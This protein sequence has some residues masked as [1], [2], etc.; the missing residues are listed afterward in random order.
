MV[1]ALLNALVSRVHEGWPPRTD[2]SVIQVH[3]HTFTC[4]CLY[5]IVTCSRA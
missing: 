3:V 4:C 2:L 1:S 5:I